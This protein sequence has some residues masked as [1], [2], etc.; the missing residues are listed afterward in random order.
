MTSA[1][2]YLDEKIRNNIT[3]LKLHTVSIL[4]EERHLLSNSVTFYESIPTPEAIFRY[5]QC[6]FFSAELCVECVTISLVIE[7]P[8]LPP[9]ISESNARKYRNRPATG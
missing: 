3:E 2:I 1:A 9:D 6:L 8:H 7:L 4:S 5:L